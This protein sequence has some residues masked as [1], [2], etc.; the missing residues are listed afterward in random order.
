MPQIQRLWFL[1]TP[2][3]WMKLERPLLLCGPSCTDWNHQNKQLGH[4][5][6]ISLSYNP[7]CV[8]QCVLKY[9]ESHPKCSTVSEHK[10]VKC[11]G[12]KGG[13]KY[14]FLCFCLTINFNPL[15]S[16]QKLKQGWHCGDKMLF[17]KSAFSCFKMNDNFFPTSLLDPFI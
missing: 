16:W 2:A 5:E 14:R 15:H 12:A 9:V 1:Y 13:L 6:L 7:L 4:R 10:W 17:P 8:V 11:H 3:S